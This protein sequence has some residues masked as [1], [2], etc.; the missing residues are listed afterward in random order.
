MTTQPQLLNIAL[1][2]QDTVY[3]P[4]WLA[5]DMVEFFKPTGTILDPCK[6]EG[7]F[8]K[9]LPTAEWCEIEQGIDFFKWTEQ[10]NWVIGNPPYSM[11]S[12][13][14]GHSMNIADNICYLIPL[15]R[16]FNSGYFIKRLAR[17]GKIKHM[18]Y[19]A[20][21]DDLGWSIGFAIGAVHFKRDYFG[22]MHSSIAERTER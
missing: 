8:L 4:D 2:P 21:G 16:L 17:W 5:R 14:L 10:V 13:W 3:T 20:D 7:V 6:G 12:K 19:Y 18:R 9:Y 22:P 15:T 1:T 11:F